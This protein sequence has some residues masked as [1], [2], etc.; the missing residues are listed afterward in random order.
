MNR[1]GYHTPQRTEENFLKI[2]S[3]TVLEWTDSSWKNDVCDSMHCYINE[4]E[5]KYIE[6]YLPNADDED[7]DEGF[8]TFK[9]MD[10]NSTELL[11]TEDINK[12]ITFLKENN[13]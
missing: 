6:I 3:K 11:T 12:L 5:D 4:E 1:Y 7:G 8:N 9:V 2:T 10:Q 13:L